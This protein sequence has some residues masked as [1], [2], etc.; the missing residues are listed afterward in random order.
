MKLSDKIKQLQ[1]ETKDILVGHG[2][3]LD[4]IEDGFIRAVE[5]AEELEHSSK[6]AIRPLTEGKEKSNVKKSPPLKKTSPPPPA[7]IANN[8][9]CKHCKFLH[10]AFGEPRDNR[11]YWLFTEMFVYLHG[12]DECLNK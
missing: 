1:E 11:E 6:K 2:E 5:H 8:K 3:E 7:P 4:D 9:K 12:K 10:K